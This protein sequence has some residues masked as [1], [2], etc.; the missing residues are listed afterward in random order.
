MCTPVAMNPRGFAPALRADLDS[1]IRTAPFSL[2]RVWRRPRA[3]DRVERVTDERFGHAGDA[4][5]EQM[6]AQRRVLRRLRIGPSARGL[7]LD[8][9]HGYE[10][11]TVVDCTPTDRACSSKLARRIAATMRT[12]S[13]RVGQAGRSGGLAR[14]ASET[15]RDATVEERQC[16]STSALSGANKPSP[17]CDEPVGSE[18]AARRPSDHG[19]NRL[20]TWA[21]A[22]QDDEYSA[23]DDQ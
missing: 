5:R 1:C 9:G 14:R 21:K 22:G 13:R 15:G 19:A 17:A 18:L 7:R 11:S 8:G 16:E 3:F 23:G 20:C 10:R 6:H 4:A 12:G 2:V